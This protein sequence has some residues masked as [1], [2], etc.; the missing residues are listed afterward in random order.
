MNN[1][2][3][4]DELSGRNVS[5]ENYEISA[6]E[7]CNLKC[8]HCMRGE[9]RNNTISQ[10]TLNNA[11]NYFNH[12][13]NLTISGGEVF[14]DEEIPSKIL[15]ALNTNVNKIDRLMIFTNATKLNNETFNLIKEI[16]E[17][18]NKNEME[19]LI[20]VSADKY[21]VDA[22][23]KAG[24]N[25]LLIKRNIE[26]LKEI[27][28]N[29]FVK[30]SA[31]CDY[32]IIN[33]GNAK[34][35]KNSLKTKIQNFK[36]PVYFSKRSNYCYLSTPLAVNCKGNLVKPNCSY[37]N[38]DLNNFGNVNSSSISEVLENL[39]ATKIKNFYNWQIKNMQQIKQCE[40]P[41]WKI[42]YGKLTKSNEK[43]IKLK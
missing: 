30:L 33:E 9:A 8:A 39:N 15:N 3:W 12:I 11:I 4:K 36:Y 7:K 31:A 37:E 10:N 26:K 20:V 25:K 43:E 41:T 42:V 22:I 38:N 29:D 32:E 24:L 5:I 35:I 27:L 16:K 13:E 28:G 17:V 14:L 23:T 19:F 34:N 40:I 2:N 18:C 1:V 6:T 21:H